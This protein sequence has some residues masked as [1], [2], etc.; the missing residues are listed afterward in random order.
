[1]KWII[2]ALL[3]VALLALYFPA[4]LSQA[5]LDTYHVDWN[6]RPA[7]PPVEVLEG[8]IDEIVVGQDGGEGKG[9][10]TASSVTE[11]SYDE[12]IREKKEFIERIDS[13]FKQ[14]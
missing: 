2:F 7:P 13:S 8:A 11:G 14:F 1:M 3:I 10:E 12:A 4:T 5:H 9:K 6:G